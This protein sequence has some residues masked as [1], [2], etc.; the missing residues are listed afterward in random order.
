L[1]GGTKMIVVVLLAGGGGLPWNGGKKV[2]SA[3]G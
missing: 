1:G 2:P 3:F